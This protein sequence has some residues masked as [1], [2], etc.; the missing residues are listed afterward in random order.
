MIVKDHMELTINIVLGNF[1]DQMSYLGAWGKL[2]PNTGLEQG[3]GS[4]YGDKSV[5]TI[6][7]V[8]M[9]MSEPSGK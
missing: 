2:F 8:A 4:V 1:H 3:I 7:S 9:H 6:M 5:P